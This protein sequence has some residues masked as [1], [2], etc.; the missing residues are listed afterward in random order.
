MFIDAKGK[1]RAD[2]TKEIM[3]VFDKG[4]RDVYNSDKWENWLAFNASFHHYSFRNRFL[5]WLQNPNAQRVA[6]MSKWN[7]LGRN[8]IKGEGAKGIK[9]WAPTEFTRIV[10]E[11]KIDEYGNQVYNPETGE[12]I[13]EKKKIKEQGF[14]PVSVYDESQTEGEP[15]PK[16]TVELLGNNQSVNTIVRA[17][18]KITGVPIF[19]DDIKNG[20]KGYFLD[21]IKNGEKKIV[22]KSDMSDEQTIKTAIHETAHAMLHARDRGEDW[23]KD[24]RFK[25]VEAESVAFIVCRNFGIDT[26]DYSFA[27]LAS[28][29]SGKDLPELKESLD[30][31]VDTA[32]T[33]CKEM[34]LF[35]RGL[36]LS[37]CAEPDALKA[38]IDNSMPL[39]EIGDKQ[40]FTEYNDKLV[41]ADGIAFENNGV[42]IEIYKSELPE[43]PVGSLHSLLEIDK[44]LPQIDLSEHTKNVDKGI[45]NNYKK[46]YFTIYYPVR[47]KDGKP[48]RDYRTVTQKYN[49]GIAKGKTL[50]EVY[51]AY[52]KSAEEL[53]GI[54]AAEVKKPEIRKGKLHRR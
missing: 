33:I 28:W 49:V 20:A 14:I 51:A 24:P 6:S 48:T 53:K 9:I 1:T 47:D 19:F 45:P 15:I 2:F 40:F 31:I 32:D 21:D 7:E 4:I 29:S 35:V 17:C 10:E 12:V 54:I 46:V 22:I 8:V 18:E 41:K 42:F 27:Y 37:N 52:S 50:S 5:I 26:S 13:T 34:K 36:N 3:D 11:P 43:L 38:Y 25:E 44:T 16:L 39:S 23:K 30:I